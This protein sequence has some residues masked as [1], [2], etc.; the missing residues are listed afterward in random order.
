MSSNIKENKKYRKYIPSTTDVDGLQSTSFKSIYAARDM[1]RSAGGTWDTF[2]QT[3][4]PGMSFFKIFFYF[5][6]K[7]FDNSDPT[8]AANLLSLDIDNNTIEGKSPWDTATYAEHTYA[9]SALNYLLINGEYERADMLVQ[10]ISLLSNINTYSPWYFTELGGIGDALE[11]KEF[12]ETDFKI[13]EERKVLT[14]KCLPD[15]IDTRI[16]TLLD[17]YR[18][19]CYSYSLKKEIIPANLRKFDMG[20]FIFNAPLFG[21]TRYKMDP[22]LMTNPIPESMQLIDNNVIPNGINNALNKVKEALNKV[23]EGAVINDF[24]N[25][26]GNWMSSSEY[27]QSAKYLEFHNCEIDPNSSKSAFDT[28]KNDE[29]SQMEYTINIWYDQCYEERYNEFLV[30]SIGDKVFAD[31]HQSQ[32]TEDTKKYMQGDIDSAG[33][34]AEEKIT[35]KQQSLKGKTNTR[36][37]YTPS[38]D[39]T[40]SADFDIRSIYYGN[41]DSEVPSNK[42]SQDTNIIQR[43]IQGAVEGLG[44]GVSRHLD[45]IMLG[46]IYTGRGVEPFLD[47]VNQTMTTISSGSGTR[48]LIANLF[49]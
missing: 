8:N 10:F 17:M 28:L 14:I 36:T 45:R 41:Q 30:R 40:T 38:G 31:L 25:F 9:N 33:L 15:A 2:N 6:N 5:D 46:N 11:R 27:C 43:N 39:T 48:S 4:T 29:G 18:E 34:K 49:S 35:N 1:F 21:L 23:K 32:S 42:Y 24:S 7:G 13:P 3:E 47:R 20:V 16:G 37:P 22:S 44:L 19:I 26:G 12:T